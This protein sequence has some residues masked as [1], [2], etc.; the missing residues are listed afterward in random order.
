MD[1]LAM[2]T[3][4]LPPFEVSLAPENVTVYGYAGKHLAL[5]VPDELVFTECVESVLKTWIA[6]P[7]SYAFMAIR[8]PGRSKSCGSSASAIVA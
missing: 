7:L 3:A 4:A 6:P 5:T 2:A 8:D 1:E